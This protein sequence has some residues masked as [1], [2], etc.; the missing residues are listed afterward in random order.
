MRREQELPIGQFSG[1]AGWPAEKRNPC[2]V[3]IAS[4]RSPSVAGLLQGFENSE[5]ERCTEPNFCAVA[6]EFDIGHWQ[7]LRH[8]GI[9]NTSIKGSLDN[10][11]SQAI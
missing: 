1:D 8:L 2:V 3:V 5:R 6:L 11:N 9:D 10:Y 7:A 4:F